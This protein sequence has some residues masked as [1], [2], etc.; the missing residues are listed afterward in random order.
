MSGHESKKHATVEAMQDR[1][2]ELELQAS[3]ATH[4]CENCEAIGKRVGDLE[5]CAECG[6]EGSDG[7]LHHDEDCPLAAF[8][9]EE[10]K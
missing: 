2:H 9:D 10:E 4:W 1:I 8:L 5:Y 7:L 6:C 3:G